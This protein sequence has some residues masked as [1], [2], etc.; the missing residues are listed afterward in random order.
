M[1]KPRKLYILDD[2]SLYSDLLAEV[3][4]NE[5]WNVTTE[6]SAINFLEFELSDDAVLVLD[7]VMPE[8]DG[9]EVIRNLASKKIHLPLI[10]I[11][12]FD[13]RVL[14]S[15][16][17]LAEAHNMT[18]LASL[19]KPLPIN[20]FINVLNSIP[21]HDNLMDSP[22]IT[23]S[24]AV[25]DILNAIERRE[26]ILHYQPQL[27]IE[28]G[29]L[30]GVEAL[31]RWQHPE[32][33]LIFPDQFISIAENNDLIDALTTEVVKIAVKQCQKWSESDL[34]F[35]ISVNISA[36]NIT[37]LSLPEQLTKL[38]QERRISADKFNLEITESDVMSELTS[39]LDVL[40]RLRM[41]G[42]SLSID[43]FGTGYSSLSQLYQAPFSEL[44][45]DL[46]FVMR[47]LEDKEAM[48]I[49]KTCIMLSHMMGMKVVAEGVETE[50]IWNKLKE[51]NCDI[52]QGYYIAKPMP[53]EALQTW[54][55]ER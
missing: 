15:A 26:F 7:L 54:L 48:V 13:A 38:T 36:A 28:T 3:A 42:F 27:N 21:L 25:A 55:S 50:K 12:G 53:A 37:S 43:D 23:T 19:N 49:V 11:S 30:Y 39:S 44:K 24:F 14:H 29:A 22:K 51:L 5:G 1:N 17:Q 32:Q 34:D 31:V 18:V 9:I 52:A 2:D 47:M 4:Q 46:Q 16:K 6:Q 10:L 45:I 8:M 33:G 41:R 20:E 40:N 35:L